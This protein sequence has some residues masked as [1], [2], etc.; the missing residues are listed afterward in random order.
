MRRYT[1]GL[2]GREFVIDV[3]ELA[4]DRFEVV[5]GDQHY[6]VTLTADADLDKASI[7]PGLVAGDAA[8]SSPGRATAAAQPRQRAATAPTASPAAAAAAAPRRTGSGAGALC[9]P[10][11][12][13]ILELHVKAGDVVQRGQQ[14]AV[15]E[16]MKM[17]NVIGAP[18]AGTIAEL[19]V[20]A[21]QTVAHGDPI[22]R[23]AE[24]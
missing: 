1:L 7:T 23:F 4:A 13:V 8:G 24:A 3:Q 5:V 20:A 18:R 9:A 21:G 22:V 10:M 6:E 12:G 19:C 15:L 11:P 17:H 14:I 2:G 16:A